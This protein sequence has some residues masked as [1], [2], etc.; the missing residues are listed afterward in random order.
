MYYKTK[1]SVSLCYSDTSFMCNIQGF[2]LPCI[3]HQAT[4]PAPSHLKK[5]DLETI[6]NKKKKFKGPIFNQNRNQFKKRD[7]FFKFFNI[8]KKKYLTKYLIFKTKYLTN[9]F[10]NSHLSFKFKISKTQ[11]KRDF[12]TIFNRKW[13]L[14]GPPIKIGISGTCWKP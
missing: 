13:D 9:I 1:K 7:H 6:F 2:Q 11:K 5:R 10:Q 14:Y 8:S 4:N 3:L 12:G